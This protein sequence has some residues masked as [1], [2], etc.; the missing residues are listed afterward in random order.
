[1][2][3]H[4]QCTVCYN[5]FI[6]N[7]CVICNVCCEHVHLSC[8]DAL[9]NLGLTNNLCCKRCSNN[10]PCSIPVDLRKKY[11]SD[12]GI[13]SVNMQVPSDQLTG[14]FTQQHLDLGSSNQENSSN[15]IFLND[16]INN[17]AIHDKNYIKRSINYVANVSYHTPQSINWLLQPF[18]KK[19]KIFLIHF[20]CLSLQKN[21]D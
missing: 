15:F 5:S 21:V 20:N 10:K 6:S 8:C 17:V 16:L 11:D 12:H 14:R 4:N 1:M 7:T 19:T 13:P 18:D 9:N 3:S 2:A